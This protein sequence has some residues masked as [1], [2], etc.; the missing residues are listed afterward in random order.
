MKE[1]KDF[2]HL[3]LGC[4]CVIGD[5]N[6]KETIQA[7]SEYSICTGS[8]KHGVDSWYKIPSV[9]PILRP[10]SD[11]TEEEKVTLFDLEISNYS[12]YKSKL[13]AVDLWI[14]RWQRYPSTE[15]GK[16][17]PKTFLFLLSK[18]FD[19]FGLIESGLAIDSKTLKEKI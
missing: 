16:W 3:Y 11:M 9:K 15:F 8:N 14:Q 2:I 6:V 10:L 18:H 4:E 7:V 1:L 13:I 5:S 17:F 12:E 19:I